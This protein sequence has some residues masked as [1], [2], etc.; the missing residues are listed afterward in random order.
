MAKTPPAE[1]PSDEQSAPA[2]SGKGRATPTRAEQEAARRRPLVPDTKEAKA[3]A[4]AD[5]QAQRERARA[6]MAA[7]DDKFLPVRDKGPQ[8]RFVRD[9]VDSGWH[10]AEWIM[11]LMILVI[12]VS[13]VG[14]PALQYYSFFALWGFVLIAIADMI[15]TGQLAKRAVRRKF[16]A[17]KLERG[18]AWYAGMRT[19]QMRFLRLPKPQVKRGT[20]LT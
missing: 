15:V 8:R 6:G 17:D 7:G 19:M 16:G 12:L 10:L 3:K 13:F 5:L 4:R 20:K 2:G 9:Y 14:I 1:V 18:T 11:P